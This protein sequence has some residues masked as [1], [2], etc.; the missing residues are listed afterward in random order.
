MSEGR[1]YTVVS[2]DPVFGSEAWVPSTTIAGS[3]YAACP[4]SGVST[5]G[6]SD[7]I[8]T[9]T[10][11]RL[12]LSSH[13]FQAPTG[14]RITALRWGGR[15]VVCGASTGFNAVTDLRFLWNKQQ[16]L[17]GSHLSN[18]AELSAALAAVE[19]GAIRPVI[20][21]VLSLSEVGD[22]QRLMEELKV[23]GKVVYVP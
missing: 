22:G 6:I 7:R 16:N 10:G 14:T 20:D 11:S 8:T 19:R 18:K 12:T 4:T 5:R 2:C 1:P 21:R 17:L 23:Q 15:I 3:S 13:T 9:P